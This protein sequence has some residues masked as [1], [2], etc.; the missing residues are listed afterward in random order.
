MR[1]F[2]NWNNLSPFEY[3]YIDGYWDPCNSNFR[4]GW[5]FSNSVCGAGFGE[6]TAVTLIRYNRYYGWM[7]EAG[8][9]FNS[10]VQ[11]DVYSGPIRRPVID[12]RRVATHELG[13]GLG[14][15]D[16]YDGASM[17]TSLMSG[18]VHENMPERPQLD[19]IR[20]LQAIYGGRDIPASIT[21]IALK[22]NN[23][24]YLVAE[25][26]GGE[27]IYANRN[28]PGDWETFLMVDLGGGRIA[29]MAFNGQYLVAEGGGGGLIYANRN[30]IGDWETFTRVNLGGNRVALRANN[31]QYLV[32]E[33]GGGQLIYADRNGTGD[34]ETFVI[35]YR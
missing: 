2:G 13:H 18:Y 7:A 15:A 14:L 29:L 21:P 31:G 26:G 27:A 35:E 3:K 5:K 12:F 34:W 25:G 9:I 30:S 28:S 17:H 8:I 6:A 4:D 23:E 1:A 22:A 33:G 10:S 32:A 20:G 11:W 16:L 24:Q 19:D